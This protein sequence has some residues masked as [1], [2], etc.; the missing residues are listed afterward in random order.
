LGGAE[1]KEDL[2]MLKLSAAVGREGFTLKQGKESKA[3]GWRRKL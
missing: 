2:E 1:T 3:R